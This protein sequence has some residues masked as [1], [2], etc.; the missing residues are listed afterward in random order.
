MIICQHNFSIVSKKNSKKYPELG[1]R[2]NQ[3]II[4]SGKNKG[5]FAQE[6]GVKPQN[7][8]RWLK[9]EV[10]PQYEFML[11]IGKLTPRSFDWLLTGE[12]KSYEMSTVNDVERLVVILK[13]PDVSRLIWDF[14]KTININ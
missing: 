5:E 4:F 6:I 3:V 10:A 8:S 11:K 12:E 14:F 1:S 9:G 13:N 7:L 2:I